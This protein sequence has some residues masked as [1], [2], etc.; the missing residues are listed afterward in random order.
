[1]RLRDLI[2]EMFTSADLSGAIDWNETPSDVKDLQTG[3]PSKLPIDTS[4]LK[5]DK[6]KKKKK[7]VRREP[8]NTL[9]ITTDN[10]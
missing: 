2:N 7:I 6:N 8:L 9:T 3:K 10:I 1:M 4:I 5:K